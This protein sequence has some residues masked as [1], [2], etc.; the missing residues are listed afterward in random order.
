MDPVTLV[1]WL[2][3]IIAGRKDVSPVSVAKP[4]CHEVMSNPKDPAIL[5]ILRS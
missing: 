3:L 2:L 5:K 1:L 4:F